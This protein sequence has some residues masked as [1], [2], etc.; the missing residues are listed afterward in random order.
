MKLK[1]FH[2][3]LLLV[4]VFTFQAC[5]VNKDTLQ[6]VAQTD[7][8]SQ[9]V[10]FK[11]ETLDLLVK[12]KKKLDIRNP[13][14]F[15]RALAK[16]VYFQINTNQNYINIIQNKVKLKTSQEYLHYA[17]SKDEVKNRNDFLI[18][19]LYKL[20]YN[21]YNLK[22]EHHFTSLQYNKS[23]MLKLYQYLQ[24]IRWKI[25]TSKDNKNQYLFNT[26]QNNWQL[27]LMKKDDSNLNIIKDL[28][29]IKSKKESI[30]DSSNFSF[31]NIISEILVNIKH[32]LK[33]INVEPYDMS[34]SAIKSF[35]FI[36]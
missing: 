24:V 18:I 11:N 21:A 32:T 3:I 1:L 6:S 13:N 10:E 35:V 5:S 19:G 15:N 16:N 22:E 29:Y 36:I 4:L 9:I 2:Y 25:R 7:S 31:E 14:S 33:E 17:F 23:E 8:A 28:K 26:W 34:I 12:Y 30:Y 20:I 27:E